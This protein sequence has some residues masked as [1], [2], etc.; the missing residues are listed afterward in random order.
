M[1]IELFNL[2]NNTI[3]FKKSDDVEGLYV[4]DKQLGFLNR[5]YYKFST[6]K[7][8]DNTLYK[9]TKFETKF[10]GSAICGS[11]IKICETFDINDMIQAF[12]EEFKSEIRENKLSKLCLPGIDSSKVIRPKVLLIREDRSKPK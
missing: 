3:N 9:L 8:F 6:D 11:T 12:K 10:M 5:L 4:Y 7:L 2:V 1:N